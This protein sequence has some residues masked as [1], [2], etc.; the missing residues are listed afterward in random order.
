MD[1]RNII[2]QYLPEECQELYKKTETLD[3]EKYKKAYTESEHFSR[4]YEV[5]KKKTEALTLD[6]KGEPESLDVNFHKLRNIYTKGKKEY[7]F[8]NCTNQK[9][10]MSY[11]D[12]LMNEREVLQQKV[13]AL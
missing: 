8:E 11:F 5:L 9:D 4:F 10:F 3:I 7:F 2:I 6:D 13:D 12:C 1:T